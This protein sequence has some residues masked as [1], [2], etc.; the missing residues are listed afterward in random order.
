LISQTVVKSSTQAI[1]SMVI[2]NHGGQELT[3]LLDAVAAYRIYARAESQSEKTI[4]WI[5]D[6]VRGVLNVDNDEGTARSY[7]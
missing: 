3:N 4:S 5:S 7:V 2:F 1:P 6:A